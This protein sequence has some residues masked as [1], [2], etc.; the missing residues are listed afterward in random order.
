MWQK[1]LRILVIL[2][3]KMLRM[4]NLRKQKRNNGD[5]DALS[6]KIN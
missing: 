1:I 5:M 6:G 2:T 3:A 4:K